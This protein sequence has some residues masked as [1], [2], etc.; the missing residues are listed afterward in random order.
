MNNPNRQ[1]FDY[2]QK[3]RQMEQLRRKKLIAQRKRDRQHAIAVL[4]LVGIAIIGLIIFAITRSN[5][6][7][8]DL[9]SSNNAA[10][11][12]NTD[13]TSDANSSYESY[14]SGESDHK[15]EEI[16]G[17][18]YVDGIM[19][20]NKTYSLPETY[21]P[22]LDETALAA[23]EKMRQSAAADGLNLFISSGYRSYEYQENLYNKYAAERGSSA[24]DEVSARPGHSEH[25]SGLCMD[26]N[27]TEF[28][29]ADTEEAKWLDEHC[30]EY[31]FIIRFPQGKEEITGYEYEPWHIRYVGEEVAKEITQK[32]MCLEEYLGVTS[33]YQD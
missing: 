21:A 5:D 28:S 31:G 23:F 16:D 30:A 3:L 12:E 22:Q 2:E 11:E 32:G 4:V 7:L 17:V 27:S 18:T 25:Q 26:I 8:P 15:I 19:I 33:K 9:P 29:F 13:G 20:V 6:E 10:N 14:K 1:P 24:A